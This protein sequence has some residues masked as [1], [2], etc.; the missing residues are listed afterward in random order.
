MVE[1]KRP[2][3]T[4]FHMNIQ[5]FLDHHLFKSLFFLLWIPLAP[6]LKIKGLFKCEPVLGLF[7]L[8]YRSFCQYLHLCHTLLITITWS[9]KAKHCKHWNLFFKNPLG[10]LCP[11][12]FHINFKICMSISTKNVT[13]W[14]NGW[15][16]VD[17]IGEFRE[18]MTTMLNLPICGHDFSLHFLGE[19]LLKIYHCFQ[20]WSLVC[21][22]L[23]VILRTLYFDAI[24]Q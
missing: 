16:C 5:W 7:M 9:I 11:L 21:L 17:S 23:N 24:V 18:K 13:Y 6:L 2:K 22:W 3:F 15:N 8:Y 4:I 14:K 10:Y 20:R 1:S 19:F 12:P